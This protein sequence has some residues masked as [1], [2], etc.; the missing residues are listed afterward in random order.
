[1]S[2]RAALASEPEPRVHLAGQDDMPREPPAPILN[3]HDPRA[4][5]RRFLEAQE[6]DLANGS[7][8]NRVASTKLPL[9]KIPAGHNLRN[10]SIKRSAD[11]HLIRHELKLTSKED[12]YTQPGDKEIAFFDLKNCDIELWTSRLTALVEAHY[13]AVEETAAL[14]L[15]LDFSHLT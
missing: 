15:H 1:M 5:L 3:P 2:A 9:E 8:P 10:V 13:K 6:K 14:R 4:Y 11:L 12:S 7:K